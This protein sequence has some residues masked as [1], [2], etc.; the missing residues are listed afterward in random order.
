MESGRFEVKDINGLFIRAISCALHGKRIESELIDDAASKELFRISKYHDVSALLSLAFAKPDDRWTSARFEA[1][2]RTILFDEERS[3]ILRF[4]EENQIWYCPL[5]GIILK[6]YYPEFGIREMGDNDILVDDTKADVIRRFMLDNGY[7]DHPLKS[8]NHDEYQKKPIYNFEIHKTLFIAGNEFYDYY[9][10]IKKKLIKDS[11]NEFGF[12]FSKEDFYIHLIAHIHRHLSENGSG[13]RNLI[14][15]YL[16]LS[17]EQGLDHDYIEHELNLLGLSDEEKLMRTL[18]FKLF[19]QTDA[20][21]ILNETESALL[22][23]MLY[24]GV[25]GN[26]KYRALIG[27]GKLKE[28]DGKNYK[29]RYLYKRIFMPED[30]LKGH[31]PFFYKHV[32]ARPFLAVF[33]VTRALLFKTKHVVK[34]LKTVWKI[35]KEI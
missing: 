24:S 7:S 4:F 2:R 10:D 21:L 15:L 1:I 34:E 12:H 25:Y 13:I 9:K 19:S 31:F 23:I 22:D 16:Y 28:D 18:A 5:K 33:R 27:I 26:D 3:K 6:D 17:K 30:I 8:S 29:I 20:E 35:K 14:D 32:W 11:D